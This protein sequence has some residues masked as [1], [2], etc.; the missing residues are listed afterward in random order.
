[1][2]TSRAQ[3]IR[4]MVGRD[5]SEEYPI[6]DARPGVPVLEVRHLSAPPRVQDVSLTVR[7][8][9]IVGVAGLVGAGRTSAGLAIVGRLPANGDVRVS[10][11]PMRFR[12]P[13]EAIDHG[14]AYVTDDRKAA[15]IFPM[16]GVDDNITLT[17]MSRFT[18]AGLLLEGK[19]RR[20]AADFA[21][22][23]DVRAARLT[24]PIVTLSGGNQQKALL[25]RYLVRRPDVLILDEPT[26]GVDVGARRQIYEAMHRL[27]AEGV[28]ILMMSSDLPEVIG[29]SDRIVVMRDGRV[30]TE[31]SRAEAT[32][33][34]VMTAATGEMAA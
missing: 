28:G 29:M 2:D 4:D 13:H 22:Q 23:V 14:V 10:G 6:R 11:R 27:T 17:H 7:Q 30:V 31:L 8:G 21:R 15:G 20:V 9:E 5:V 12:S 19:R 32:P 1:V 33:D 34:A 3:I 18:R 25:A 26:R 24:Q 16:M